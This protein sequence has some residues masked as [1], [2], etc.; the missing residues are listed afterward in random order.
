MAFC[1]QCGAQIPEDAKFCPKCGKS[2]CT[3]T[4]NERRVNDY[5]G[6]IIKCP[7]CGEPLKSFQTICPVCG[8]ELREINVSSSLKK[9]T[10]KLEEINIQIGQSKKKVRRAY[11]SPLSNLEVQKIGLI[12]SYPIPN[13]RE[14]LLEFLILASSNVDNQHIDDWNDISEADRAISNAWLAKYNQ[15]YQKAILSFDDTEEFRE[16]NRE[17]SAVVKKNKIKKHVYISLVVVPVVVGCIAMFS[18]IFL[19]SGS[20]Q[21]KV[22]AENQRLTEIVAQINESL[23]QEEYGK[24]R[25]LTAS[26]VFTVSNNT[27]MAEDSKE[28]WDE[29]RKEYY[30]VIDKAETGIDVSIPNLDEGRES[31]VLTENTEIVEETHEE[32]GTKVE[33]TAPTT[34][35]MEDI[36]NAAGDIAND[37]RPLAG[38]L[39]DVLS[40]FRDV[41]ESVKGE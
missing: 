12:K 35:V 19:W 26:L 22:D 32:V 30:D 17:F 9:F 1:M 41:I 38:D 8:H 36:K 11:N 13:T 21:K 24:A 25:A 37:L 28:N 34:D 4:T 2:I 29:V 18:A 16:L 5:A 15:A 40:E 27:N 14:D 33:E 10:D 31:T 23:E 39:K 7:S 6:K 3:S 20:D